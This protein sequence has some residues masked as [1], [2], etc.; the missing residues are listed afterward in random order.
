M[1][2]QRYRQPVLVVP[3]LSGREF[4]M[5]VVGAGRKARVLG[6]MEVLLNERAKPG[7]YGYDNKAHFEGRV[8][9]RLVKGKLA[10]QLDEVALASWRALACRDGGRLD[11]KL[12]GKGVPHFL[13][14]NPL[15]GLNPEISYLPLSADCVPAVFFCSA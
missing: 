4:T 9:R 8:E 7:A 10:A 3:F 6:V 11:L 2:L 12:D 14:V 5:G 13:E 15:A 1:L